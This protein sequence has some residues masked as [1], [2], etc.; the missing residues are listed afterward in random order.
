MEDNPAET[1]AERARR[2]VEQ[3]KQERVSRLEAVINAAGG[4]A[5]LMGQPVRQLLPVGVGLSTR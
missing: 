4:V 3:A 1:L 2:L 5:S